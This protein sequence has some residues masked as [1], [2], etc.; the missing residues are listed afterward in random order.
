MQEFLARFADEIAQLQKQTL[1]DVVMSNQGRSDPAWMRAKNV[2]VRDFRLLTVEERDLLEDWE[3]VLCKM[4]T[5]E[6]VAFLPRL[7]RCFKRVESLLTERGEALTKSRSR[8]YTACYAKP[9]H[10]TISDVDFCPGIFGTLQWRTGSRANG[11]HGRVGR[12]TV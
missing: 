6:A 11:S 4:S 12:R 8:E 2:F 5:L 7:Q 10:A 1:R 9:S 3:F